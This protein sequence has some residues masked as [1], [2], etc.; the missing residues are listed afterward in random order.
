MGF[1][2]YNNVAV[3]AAHARARGV[4]RVAIVD[5]DVHHG[6]GTQEMFYADPSRALR[7]DA[8]V[9]VLPG[10][11]RGRPSRAAERATG[12]TVNVPLEAGATDGDYVRV[13]ELGVLPV[14][15][16]FSPGLLLVSAGFDAHERDPL[17]QMRMTSAG[18]RVDRRGSSRAMADRMS[19]GR[20]CW[21]P[22][23]ATRC[24]RS[25]ESLDARAL[26]SLAGDADGCPRPAHD[27]AVRPAARRSRA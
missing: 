4:A 8:P 15:D 11:R 9:P 7:L 21:S 14:L 23:A 18:L 3:A 12:F 17:A 2:F 1:C 19:D 10:H 16:E 13:F 22:R 24:R 26:R 5:F 6:N 27:A 20:S 25:G